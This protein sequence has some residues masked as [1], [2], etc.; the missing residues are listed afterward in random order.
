MKDQI[1]TSKGSVRTASVGLRGIASRII[2]HDRTS[3]IL[4]T[5]FEEGLVKQAIGQCLL[6]CADTLP[7]KIAVF[8]S[9]PELDVISRSGLCG[10]LASAFRGSLEL[11]ELTQPTLRDFTLAGQ[12]SPENTVM[13][14][15]LGSEKRPL[16]WPLPDFEKLVAS[17][18]QLAGDS[19]SNGRNL[20]FG[21]AGDWLR[22]DRRGSSSLIDSKAIES[23]WW[24]SGSVAASAFE[25]SW[26]MWASVFPAQRTPQRRIVVDQVKLASRTA[27]QLVLSSSAREKISQFIKPSATPPGKSLVASFPT[28]EAGRWLFQAA[29]IAPEMLKQVVF[30]EELYGWGPAFSFLRFSADYPAGSRMLVMRDLVSVDLVVVE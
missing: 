6:S 27:G 7:S 26:G 13:V 22:F 25:Y 4:G 29:G 28:P 1:Q 9:E 19:N 20:S 17:P 18:P 2:T 16:A 12:S 15:L 5:R 14:I 23:S 3:K 21:C 8:V 10:T 30:C 24:P 11:R